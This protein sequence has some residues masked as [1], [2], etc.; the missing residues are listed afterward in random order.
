MRVAPSLALA[1]LALTQSPAPERATW[2]TKRAT[3]S[4]TSAAVYLERRAE[5]WMKWPPARRDR[6]TVCVSCHTT[7]PYALARSAIGGDASPV[8]R[9]LF[10]SVTTRVR[11]WNDTV[12]YYANRQGDERKAAESR[13]T[14]AVLNALILASRDVR[15]GV[16][17]SDARLAFERMWALQ[18]TDGGWPW[19]RFGLNPWEGPQSAYFGAAMAA[20]AVGSAPPV[21]RSTPGVDVRVRRLRSFLTANYSGQPLANRAVLL[22][23]GSKLPGAVDGERMR[24]I[25]ADLVRAQRRG[26]G[27]STEAM[28]DP[29]PRTWFSGADGYATALAVLALMPTD[30]RDAA[31]RGIEWLVRNQ[32][33]SCGC[34][35]AASLN[36]TRDAGSDAAPF[37]SDAATGFAVLAL[38]AYVR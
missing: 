31:Q 6:G 35:H 18:Q 24:A 4:D 5:W 22:W 21:Y 16:L 8:E 37:M 38:N 11:T 32:D 27:W 10:D 1:L 14:E 2:N 17:S 25:A 36:A 12:P 19:L 15:A 34:W 3:W 26:G 13:G 9:R 28:Q 33:A 7:L 23:A 30:A 29:S 20:L